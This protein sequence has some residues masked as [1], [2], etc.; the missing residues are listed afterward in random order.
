MRR[1]TCDCLEQASRKVECL[2]VQDITARPLADHAHVVLPSLTFAEK[3]GTFT[4][5]AGACSASVQAITAADGQPSDGEIFSRL[6]ARLARPPAAFDPAAVLR[7]D[8][9]GAPG[10]CRT[11][12]RQ[13]RPTGLAA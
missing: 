12:V 2:I 8:R 9:R 11:D 10:V 5:I 4:N 3:N 13:C 7:G 6:L 1:P